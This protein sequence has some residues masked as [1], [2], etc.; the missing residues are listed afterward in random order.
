MVRSHHVPNE[1]DFI[2]RYSIPL[3][4]EPGLL[5]AEYKENQLSSNLIITNITSIQ[6]S[7]MVN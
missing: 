6:N 2:I 5:A 7:S 4:L 3:V 1:C